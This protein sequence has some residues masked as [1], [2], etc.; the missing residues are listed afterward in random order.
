MAGRRPH[1]FRC[2]HAASEVQF[3]TMV[4]LEQSGERAEWALRLARWFQGWQVIL[5]G[6]ERLSMEKGGADTAPTMDSLMYKLSAL[7]VN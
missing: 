4:K 7:K 6:A 3:S 1:T 2:F 5:V